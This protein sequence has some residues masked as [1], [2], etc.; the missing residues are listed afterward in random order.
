[1]R[2]KIGMGTGIQDVLVTMAEGN[3][4]ALTVLMEIMKKDGMIAFTSVLSLDDMNI[5]GE[6]IWIGFKYFCEQN[7]EKFL[8]CIKSRDEDMIAL[9]NKEASGSEIAVKSGASFGRRA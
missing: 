4:G 6:Q 7:L 5:R 8:G 9:I 3:I 1:M 2:A